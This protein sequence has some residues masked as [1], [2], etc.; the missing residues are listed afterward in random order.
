MSKLLD[1]QE[2]ILIW[3]NE[4]ILVTTRL[5]PH[6][7]KHDG[8]HILSHQKIAFLRFMNWSKVY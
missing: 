4:N 7:S 1:N 5:I 2:K 8:G 6:I 3:E